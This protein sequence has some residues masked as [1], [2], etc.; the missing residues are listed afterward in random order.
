[1]FCFGAASDDPVG[2]EPAG[3]EDGPRGPLPAEGLATP[4]LLFENCQV[5]TAVPFEPPGCIGPTAPLVAIELDPRIWVLAAE[6]SDTGTAHSKASAEIGTC[7]CGM[8][9]M[10]CC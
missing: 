10:V 5:Q 8:P 9:L 1:M 2:L 7:D 3:F 4:P 6:E